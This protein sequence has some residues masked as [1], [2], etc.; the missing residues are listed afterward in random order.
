[1]SYQFTSERGKRSRAKGRN[2]LFVIAILLVII[3]GILLKFSFMS[4]I[5]QTVGRPLW[6]SESVGAN[7]VEEIHGYFSS[8]ASLI[9]ENNSLKNQLN[10]LSI[11]A[12]VNDTLSTENESLK[13]L[14]GRTNKKSLL[15]ATIIDRPSQS[16]YDTLIVDVG[17]NNMVVTGQTVLAENNIP[18]GTVTDLYS[19]SSRVTLYSSSGQKLSVLV[20]KNN[21]KADAIGQGG[22]NFI[23]KIPRG[24]PIQE[25][26]QIIAPSISTSLYGTV[27]HIDLA[28]NDSFQT[29][30][31]N[32]PVN[33]N[34]LRFVYLIK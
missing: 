22:G 29:I 11:K 19:D 26:D 17:S 33:L 18:I 14:L 7:I 21:V 2:I 6:K 10:D 30:Y 32:S 1:M 4:S 16:P 13:E 25:G 8:K 28:P 15:L 24:V 23:I 12:A 3:L 34:Q 20:G 9:A 31:F 27:S 5:V